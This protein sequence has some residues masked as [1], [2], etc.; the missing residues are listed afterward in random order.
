VRIVW[1]DGDYVDAYREIIAAGS[2][3]PNVELAQRF[4]TTAGAVAQRMRRLRQSG[5]LTADGNVLRGSG[6]CPYCG[7][8][9]SAQRPE[10]AAKRREAGLDQPRGDR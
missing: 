9:P 4:G 1:E 5:R 6:S 7:A 2:V 8:L 10:R 3:R